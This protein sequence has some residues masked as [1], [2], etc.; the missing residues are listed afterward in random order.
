ME[1]ETENKIAWKQF[2][3]YNIALMSLLAILIV[4]LVA[5]LIKGV[6]L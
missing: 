3:Y 5:W 4:L 2:G 6:E 1:N